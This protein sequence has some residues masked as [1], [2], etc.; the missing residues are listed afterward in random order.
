MAKRVVHPQP[1]DAEPGGNSKEH[2]HGEGGCRCPKRDQ[3][4]AFGANY[5]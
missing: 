1:H 5:A 2:Q 4:E 3:T